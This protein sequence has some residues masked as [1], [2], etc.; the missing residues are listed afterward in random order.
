[1]SS[2][3]QPAGISSTAT[4]RVSASAAKRSATTTSVGSSS[5]HPRAPASVIAR[6]AIAWPSASSC[7]EPPRRSPAAARN[8]NAIAP[9]IRIESA[10]S[11]KRSITPILSAT[12]TPADHDH[13]RVLGLV[14]QLPERIQ[15]GLQQQ[16]GRRRQQVGDA[17]GGGVR[18]MCGAEGIVHVHVGVPGQLGRERGIV[19]L[20]ARDRTADSRA[21]AAAPVHRRVQPA[22]PPAHSTA[23][24]RG[25]ATIPGWFRPWVGPDA[26]SRSRSPPGQAGGGWSAV[27]PG[28]GRRR[29][30]RRRAVA[31][32]D[33]PARAPA[34]PRPARPR[35]ISARPQATLLMRSTTRQE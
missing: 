14:Q 10:S 31:H 35:P 24:P 28:C 29:P 1:M 15:L 16:P 22:R 11:V 5:S 7:R 25:A 12:L 18:S 21:A 23:R 32:S 34:G 8:V 17:L 20:F 13:E 4:V 27:R 30:P 3:I 19:L 6:R 9:P 33:R 26:T 2:P